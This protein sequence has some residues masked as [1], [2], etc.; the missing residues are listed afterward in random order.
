MRLGAYGRSL[1]GIHFLAA[2]ILISSVNCAP[3]VY[4]NI[5]EGHPEPEDEGVA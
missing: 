4:D 3:T 1:P 5:P 2:I